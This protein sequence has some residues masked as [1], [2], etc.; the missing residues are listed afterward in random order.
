MLSIAPE[1]SISLP[2]GETGVYTIAATLG[3]VTREMTMHVDQYSG[4]VLADVRWKDYD[5]VPQAVE[6]GISIHM[7][8]YFGF[9]N[10]LLML[11]ACLIVILL[12][13][14]GLVLWWQRRPEGRLG[15]PTMLA[16]DGQPSKIPLAIV[17]VLGVAFPLVGLSLV[18]VLA[19][20]YFVIARIP[21][22][23]KLLN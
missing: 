14:S 22:L 18:T 8:K 7:G 9:A 11:A 17:A 6:I 19:L 16:I 13:V 4:K 5:L 20:D 15:A 1:Y 12:C 10:Q 23:R 3:D 2:D 21:A